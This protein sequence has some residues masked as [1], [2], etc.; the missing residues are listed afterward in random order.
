[1][2]SWRAVNRQCNA[3]IVFHVNI[4]RHA[5]MSA[6][7]RSLS[8]C[9]PTCVFTRAGA[10]GA[11]GGE[12]SGEAS[13]DGGGDVL[14]SEGAPFE[15]HLWRAR[16]A[17]QR[18]TNAMLAAYEVRVAGGGGGGDSAGAVFLSTLC[19]DAVCDIR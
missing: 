7:T 12:A 11:E 1:M 4:V 19:Y 3:N 15:T 14:V 6:H 5:C 9:T 8:V 16:L 10:G 13:Q 17:I 2:A 18:A